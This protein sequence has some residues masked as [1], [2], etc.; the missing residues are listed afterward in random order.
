MPSYNSLKSRL[1]AQ[2]RHPAHITW[3]C[4]TYTS[5]PTKSVAYASLH[6]A[7]NEIRADPMLFWDLQQGKEGRKGL[8][9]R[10]EF[11]RKAAGFVHKRLKIYELARYA[12]ALRWRA[13]IRDLNIGKGRLLDEAG[14]TWGTKC[15]SRLPCNEFDAGPERQGEQSIS[16]ECC[17]QMPLALR[18]L[19]I[20]CTY[21]FEDRGLTAWQY[22]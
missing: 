1:R 19:Q 12:C 7:V 8:W 16:Y 5:A 21:G 22:N 20:L 15:M 17:S 2:R 6:A 11:H 14:K 18:N 3:D 13:S 9:N 10:G 4:I